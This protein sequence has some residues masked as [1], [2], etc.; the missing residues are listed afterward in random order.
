[1]AGVI[2]DT[3]NSQNQW[4]ELPRGIHEKDVY[5]WVAFSAKGGIA[6]L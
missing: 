4:I 1:M 2:T 5:R 6:Y 3:N